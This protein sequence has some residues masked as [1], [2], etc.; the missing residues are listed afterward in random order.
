M[1][2]EFNSVLLISTLMSSVWRYLHSHY[3]FHFC[4]Y[5]DKMLAVVHSGRKVLAVSC[6]LQVISYWG[7]NSKLLVPMLIYKDITSNSDLVL[8]ILLL[9]LFPLN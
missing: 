3:Y 8:L 7:I 6:K 4:F 1:W 5:Y 9:S 2:K